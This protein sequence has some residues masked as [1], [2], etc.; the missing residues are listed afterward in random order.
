ME[1]DHS[2]KLLDEY[3]KR[4]L[5]KRNENVLGRH[6]FLHWSY[7]YMASCESSKGNIV[8]IDKYN[9]I[10]DRWEQ[11]QKIRLS[12]ERKHFEIVLLKTGIFII[13]GMVSGSYVKSVSFSIALLKQRYMYD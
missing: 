11:F 10:T 4:L 2:W 9:A 5:N 3:R 12:S 8:N 7:C 1:H 6:R 13:G